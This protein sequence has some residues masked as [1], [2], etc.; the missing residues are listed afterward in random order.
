MRQT[1]QYTRCE[2]SFGPVYVAWTE[3]GIACLVAGEASEGEFLQ[4]CRAQTGVVPVRS[5]GRQA[6]LTAMLEGWLAGEPYEGP[7]D[8][9]GQTP[10]IQTVLAV[11]RAIPRGQVRTY[12]QLAAAVGKPGA[13]RAVGT[14]MRKNPVPWLI[15]CHRVVRTDGV[16]GNFSMGGPAV[17]ERL[18]RLEGALGGPTAP[19]RSG[20]SAAP[21]DRRSPAR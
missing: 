19:A 3:R 16:I 13:A 1:M 2:T 6:E 7:I 11:C 20:S 17:K 21:G 15:P 18:L 12:A 8:L 14:A 4:R 9:S 5:D 10:F